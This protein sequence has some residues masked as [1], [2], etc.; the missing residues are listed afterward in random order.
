MANYL[1]LMEAS[2]WQLLALLAICL[3]LF[4]LH[5]VRR[6]YSSVAD[7]GFLLFIVFAFGAA[8]KV[9]NGT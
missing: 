3:A 4:I 8:M 2:D 1:S 9:G 5:F 6:G 7:P